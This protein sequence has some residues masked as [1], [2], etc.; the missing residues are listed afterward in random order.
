MRFMDSLCPQWLDYDSFWGVYVILQ[1]FLGLIRTAAQ[2]LARALSSS[3]NCE[4]LLCSYV[5]CHRS[6]GWFSFLY[7]CPCF[8]KW[9]YRLQKCLQLE[10]SLAYCLKS[11]QAIEKSWWHI[12]GQTICRVVYPYQFTTRRGKGE[13]TILLSVGNVTIFSPSLNKWKPGFNTWTI[14]PILFEHTQSAG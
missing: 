14:L 11:R 8:S 1:K 6:P 3:L 10:A 13:Y 5:C 9:Y 7:Y 2:L 12:I 4:V